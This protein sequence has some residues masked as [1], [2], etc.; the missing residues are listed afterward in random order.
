LLRRGVECGDVH[1][2]EHRH[3]RERLHERVRARARAAAAVTA[4]IG[5]GAV[6]Q[7]RDRGERAGAGDDPEV[8][9]LAPAEPG[10]DDLL[11]FAKR[12]AAETGPAWGTAAHGLTP[13]AGSGELIHPRADCLP[14]VRRSRSKRERDSRTLTEL[15]HIPQEFLSRKFSQKTVRSLPVAKSG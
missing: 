7:A 9:H 3:D 4:V 15:T 10:L 12:G 11:T 14:P 8:Q 2:R 1:G 6:A 13:G 5:A